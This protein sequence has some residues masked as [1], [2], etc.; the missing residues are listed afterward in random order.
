MIRADDRWLLPL[1]GLVSGCL[2][3]VVPVFLASGCV[4]GAVLSFH[5]WAFRGLRSAFRAVG[6]VLTCAVAYTVSV[7]ATMFSPFR[8]EFLNFSGTSLGA[9]DS[10]PF[11][12]GGIVGAAIVCAGFYFF[13]APA[14]NWAKFVLKAL[15]ICV[16][17]GFLGVFGWALGERMGEAGWFPSF[18]ENLDFYMLYIVWQMGTA[19]L[20]G[21]LLP[22]QHP[23][24]TAPLS[25]RASYEMAH[26]KAKGSRPSV[27]AFAFLA[28]VVAAMGWFIVRQIQGER[29][30]RRVRATYAQAEARRIAE[31]P[32]AE[33]LPPIEPLP[34]DQVLVLRPIAGHPAG[35]GVDRGTRRVPFAS[36]PAVPQI[37][38]WV[39]YKRSESA[40]EIESSFADVSVTICPN[41]DW[42][43]Y[44]TKG[45]PQWTI[46][47]QNPQ[48]IVTVTKF[49]NKV[50][51]NT[52]MRYPTGGGDLY[53]YWVSGNRFVMVRFSD[54]EEDE[55]L[56]EY[57][58]LHPSTL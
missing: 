6:F 57:L 29:F 7:Y 58:E 35:N 3:C 32:S 16:A 21:L 26:S 37:T 55:F 8:A 24:P 13:V 44:A 47:A 54:S 48:D 40:S 38:Y 52:T 18:G 14:T 10:S 39:A 12:T 41:R 56:K 30:G 23:V 46:A 5:C 20:L 1:E 19:S 33:N 53:F 34:V 11:L 43:I 25:A 15:C 50:I 31:R 45:I 27:A 17:C 49:G 51:M 2:T 4:F 9:V 22:G 28:L 36:L 42:A